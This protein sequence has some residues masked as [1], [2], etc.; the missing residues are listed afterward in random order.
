MQAVAPVALGLVKGKVGML[1]QFFGAVSIVGEDA[2]AMLVVITMRRP[3][4]SIGS[5]MRCMMRWAR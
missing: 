5:F 2:D 4:R 3:P 1:E